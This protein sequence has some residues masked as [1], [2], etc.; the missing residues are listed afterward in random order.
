[1]K[2][3]K[4]FGALAL[5]ATAVV[6]LAACS[7]AKSSGT[8]ASSGKETTIK[9]GIMTRDDLMTE[10]WTKIAEKAKAK[11]VKIEL[12][13]YTDY[14]QPNK[15]LNQGDVDI[16]A[17]QHI[18]FLNNWNSK[19]NAELQVA[20]Y[21]L[22]TPIRLY[23][24]LNGDK[25]KYSSV[26]AIPEKAT[27]GIPNDPTNE[28]R[29]LFLLEQAGLIKL[30]VKDNGLA[31]KANITENKKQLD[32]KELSADQLVR[33]RGS[34]DASVINTNY[35]QQGGIN[36]KTALFIEQPS[37]IT[38][39]WYNVIAAPKGWEKSDKADAIKAVVESF[40]SE[41]IAK[42]FTEKTEGAQVPIWDKVKK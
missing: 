20:G 40:N 26:D 9:I 15:A 17:F 11:G 18:Y 22:Y 36:V 12:K 31:T 32:I 38:E 39:Q 2:L 13:E 7:P 3:K 24:G 42:L 14:S 8:A 5:A 35:A 33:A 4:L 25:E 10:A 6:A 23:S 41:D 16:N 30:D 34:L 1:M 27:I 28:S 37:N 29:A 21:T 19:N